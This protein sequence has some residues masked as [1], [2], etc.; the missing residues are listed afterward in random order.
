MQAPG[1]SNEG[2]WGAALGAKYEGYNS[3][4]EYLQK[5]GAEVH[6]K[7]CILVCCSSKNAAAPVILGVG[8]LAAKLVGG[9]V[10]LGCVLR[11]LLDCACTMWT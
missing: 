4:V 2:R 6:S 8:M 9:W 10:V 7:G 11:L 1:P 3:H 5:E